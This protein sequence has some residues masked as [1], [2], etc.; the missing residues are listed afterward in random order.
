MKAFKPHLQGLPSYPYKKVDASV[1]LDQNESPYDLPAELKQRVLQRLQHLDFNRYPPL[2]AE[3]VRE[4][5][6]AYLDWPMEGLVVSPGS[7]LLIQA[8]VQAAGRVLDT[9]PSFPHYAFSARI[10]ATPYRA[11]ALGERFALPT[12]ALLE[13]LQET[14]AALFLPNPHAPTAQL[15][16][17]SDICRLADRAAQTGGLLVIDEAYHQ[18]SGTDYAWLARA[19]PHVALLRTFS[20]AW[21]L[22]GIRAGYLMASPEVC[23]VVQNFVPPFGLPAHTAQILLTVLESPGY[24]QAIVQ[25]LLGERERLFQAL[26]PHPTWKVYPSQTNFL[27]IRTPDAAAAYNALLEQGILVRRQDHYLGL[28]GCI[29]VSVGTPQENQR[30]LEAAFS[31][32]EVPHA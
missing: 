24:V 6:S 17:E 20:K 23:N 25:T 9:A 22:G 32:L 11:I 14:P 1:K 7:N 12:E 19:N 26:Q 21:G 18:F 5:L 15:F 3:D 30:F 4:K 31:L 27:L 16:A 2:H 10:S 13:A 29:R 8:L 28:E